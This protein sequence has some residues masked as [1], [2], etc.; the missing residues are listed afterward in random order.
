MEF[1]KNLFFL[2]RHRGELGFSP[3][4]L[5]RHKFTF[6]RDPVSSKWLLVDEAGLVF[7]K[8][9]RVK[10]HTRNRSPKQIVGFIYSE[11]G[12]HLIIG[13][14][15]TISFYENVESVFCKRTK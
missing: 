9:V 13:V 12:E 2:L 5:I 4:H 10:T 15:E 6:T 11:S 1:I 14:A 8:V 7:G 3:K